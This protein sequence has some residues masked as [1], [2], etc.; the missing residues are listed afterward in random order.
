MLKMTTGQVAKTARHLTRLAS[1]IRASNAPDPVKVLHEISQLAAQAQA[2]TQRSS[3]EKAEALVSKIDSLVSS[4]LMGEVFKDL[5]TLKQAEA[6]D[7]D[8]PKWS[9]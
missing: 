2:L 7:A 5:E 9:R 1:A 6:E 3:Y 8:H 4:L